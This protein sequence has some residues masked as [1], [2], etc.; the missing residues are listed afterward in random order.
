MKERRYQPRRRQQRPRS[1]WAA[2]L[3][4]FLAI[5]ITGGL[6]YVLATMLGGGIVPTP[7]PTVVVGEISQGQP[8]PTPPE[9]TPTPTPETPT[10]TPTPEEPTPTP[11]LPPDVLQVGG[12]ATVNAEAGLRVRSG[13]GTSFDLVITLPYGMVV[14]IIGGPERADTYTWWQIEFSTPDGEKQQGWVAGDFL[15]PGVQNY[16]Q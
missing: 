5:L 1:P 6:F 11:T 9:P 13:P 12:K 15:D 8:T 16:N 10:P 7:T 3:I 4:P 14:D 2:L